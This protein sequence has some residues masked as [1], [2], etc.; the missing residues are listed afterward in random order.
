MALDKGSSKKGFGGGKF[1]NRRKK[2]KEG[3]LNQ[4]WE[5]PAKILVVEMSLLSVSFLPQ[6]KSYLHFPVPF[7]GAKHLKPVTQYYLTL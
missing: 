7:P 4:Q 1:E 2:I 6:T 3:G 5:T